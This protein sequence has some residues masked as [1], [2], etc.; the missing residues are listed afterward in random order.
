MFLT[1][2]GVTAFTVSL[3][4]FV[5]SQNKGRPNFDRISPLVFHAMGLLHATVGFLLLTYKSKQKLPKEAL[6]N[7]HQ[8]PSS[9]YKKEVHAALQKALVQESLSG[10]PYSLKIKEMVDSLPNTVQDKNPLAFVRYRISVLNAQNMLLNTLKVGSDELSKKIWMGAPSNMDAKERGAL[11]WT[12]RRVFA[13]VLE[14]APSAAK[15]EAVSHLA[16]LCIAYAIP[17]ENRLPLLTYAVANIL[18]SIFI[19]RLLESRR[20][21]FA[22]RNSSLEEKKGALVYCQ[23]MKEAEIESIPFWAHCLSQVLT[24]NQTNQI[25]TS[26]QTAISADEELAKKAQEQSMMGRISRCFSL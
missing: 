21:D 8:I 20:C 14:E 10:K 17:G 22:N 23:S 19:D 12:S 1:K 11:P 2:L 25:I 3:S 6:A 9:F 26:L 4:S 18:P 13:H 5:E 16:A 15:W 24:L 7:L